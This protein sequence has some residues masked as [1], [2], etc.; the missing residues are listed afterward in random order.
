MHSSSNFYLNQLKPS[1]EEQMIEFMKGYLDMLFEYV[2]PKELLFIAIDGPPPRA[3]MMQQRERRFV[4]AYEAKM[5]AG[6]C[7]E[8]KDDEWD[9]NQITPGTAFMVK[10]AKGL[11]KYIEEKLSNN[12]DEN[13]K[14][15]IILSDSSVPGEGEHKILDFIR[16]LRS[17]KNYDTS[18]KHL[19]F[20]NDADMILL[21]LLLHEK[22]VYLMSDTPM[23]QRD[24]KRMTLFSTKFSMI[25]LKLLTRYLMVDLNEKRLNYQKF[26]Y[27]ID[28]VI[29]DFVFLS[30]FVG[31]DFIPCLPFMNMRDGAFQYLLAKYVEVASVLPSYLVN[32]CN[33][34]FNALIVY[35][36]KLRHEEQEILKCRADCFLERID[37]N[38]PNNQKQKKQQQKS[39]QKKKKKRRKLN[40]GTSENVNDANNKLNIDTLN[41]KSKSDLSFIQFGRNGYKKRYYQRKFTAEYDTKQNELVNDIKVEYIRALSWIQHYYHSGIISWKWHYKYHFAPLISDI[42]RID[43]SK[44]NSDSLWGNYEKGAPLPPLTQLSLVMPEKSAK[45]TLPPSY[46]NAIFGKDSQLKEFY[47]DSFEIDLNFKALN[48]ES[49]AIVTHVDVNFL[50]K[51]LDKCSLNKAFKAQN[52]FHNDL[53][54]LPANDKNFKDHIAEKWNC[55]LVGDQEDTNDND[56]DDLKVYKFEINIPSSLNLSRE[57]RKCERDID[58]ISKLTEVNEH[59]LNIVSQT[60]YKWFMA[61]RQTPRKITDYMKKRPNLWKK[62]VQQLRLTAKRKRRTT[63]K[64]SQ[65]KMEKKKQKKSEREK[66]EN[67]KRNDEFVSKLKSIGVRR[68]MDGNNASQLI[69]DS[70]LSAM[71][72]S[73][74]NKKE[75]DEKK[76]QNEEKKEIKMKVKMSKKF[77]KQKSA[78]I[79]VAQNVNDGFVGK[80]KHRRKMKR[81]KLQKML[82]GGGSDI[83]SMKI[84]AP[85][86]QV[87]NLRK[88]KVEN[89]GQ[90]PILETK[91]PEND[92]ERN[93]QM[94]EVQSL[95]DLNDKKKDKKKK[96]KK[97]KKK[98]KQSEITE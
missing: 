90:Y 48:W 45:I 14:L 49:T 61:G 7:T 37:P 15:K 78:Q 2:Q 22:E 76:E 1:D 82:K 68:D 31:N 23:R 47:P 86:D 24:R 38:N 80:K 4:H 20:S 89:Y 74:N 42:M 40:D 29:D 88:S 32:G 72:S 54:Y 12:G 43:P 70:V 9:S 28:R 79:K 41:K 52:E 18:S 59:Q 85:S 98:R 87:K 97:R 19:L 27:C 83:G 50:Q 39:K 3:K 93:A 92:N 81:E 11:G 33:V 6:N 96:K 62:S 8:S 60:M 53:I 46:F 17:V 26:E 75:N 73:K 36:R 10:V 63:V 25:D 16:N 84:R 57:H 51:I 44:Y 95:L 94:K 35:L 65:I 5:N 67:K 71:M 77:Q 69:I 21:S 64:A 34:N 56:D 58:E 55:P 91:G 66:K 13:G 30:Y